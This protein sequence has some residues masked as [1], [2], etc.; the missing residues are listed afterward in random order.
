MSTNGPM[1]IAY[2]QGGRDYRSGGWSNDDLTEML[3]A[4]E[5]IGCEIVRVYD[6]IAEAREQFPP[7]TRVIASRKHWKSPVGTVVT[8]AETEPCGVD[9]CHCKG[10]TCDNV[11]V[12]FDGDDHVLGWWASGLEVIAGR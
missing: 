5:E 4:M 8:D 11:P 6:G 2:R 9:N 12:R 7:G 10:W 1:V 3:P